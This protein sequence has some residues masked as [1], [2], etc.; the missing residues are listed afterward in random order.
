MTLGDE[1]R[2]PR[3]DPLVAWFC[4]R[5]EHHAWARRAFADL[6]PGCLICEAVLTEATHLVARD[7][8][9]RGKVIEFV[10]RGRLQPVSLAAELPAIGTLLER[11]ADTPM[12]FA[13]ACIVRLAEINEN[14]SVCT[15][16]SDF[17]VFRKNTQKPIPLLAPFVR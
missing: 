7:G 17:L 15:L 8:V 13:D 10:E 9:P 16:D 6:P 14:L 5:D 4:P 3:H 11:Y 2:H 1:S 12:D